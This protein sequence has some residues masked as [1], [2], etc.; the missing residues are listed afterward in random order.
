MSGLSACDGSAGTWS[1]V[2]L[3]ML[4]GRTSGGMCGVASDEINK[5]TTI[6]NGGTYLGSGAAGLNPGYR[7]V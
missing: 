5:S 6:S 1:K 7:G 4:D 2:C 3:K